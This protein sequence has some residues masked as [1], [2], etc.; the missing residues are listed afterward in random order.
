MSVDLSIPTSIQA[1]LIDLETLRGGEN[2]TGIFFAV[3][4]IATKAA[5]AMSSG[6]ALLILSYFA[7]DPK[8]ENDM[9][10]L[11]VLTGLYAFAPV[12]LKLTSVYV[13][14]NFPLDENYHKSIQCRLKAKFKY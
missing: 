3:W 8:I 9:I 7:F 10:S 13:M 6:L 11:W 1:D 5:A 4:S 2:R 14:W 12:V